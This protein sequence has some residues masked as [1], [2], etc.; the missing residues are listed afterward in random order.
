MASPAPDGSRLPEVME[1]ITT[2][3]R[4][5]MGYGDGILRLGIFASIEAKENFTQNWIAQRRVEREGNTTQNLA[6]IVAPNFQA[7]VPTTM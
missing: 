1:T 4:D 7:P 6:Q 3:K 2:N 5:L